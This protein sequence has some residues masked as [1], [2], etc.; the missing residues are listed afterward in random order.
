MEF[1][2]FLSFYST[3][4]MR[5]IQESAQQ[6][7]LLCRFTHICLFHLFFTAVLHQQPPQGQ[8]VEE[9]GQQDASGRAAHRGQR[10]TRCNG[11]GHQGGQHHGGVLQIHGALG[12]V[13]LQIV[14][15][16]V[17]EHDGQGLVAGDHTG[18]QTGTHGSGKG[19]GA[20]GELADGLFDAVQQ[21]G[22]AENTGEGG[23]QADDT[24]HAHHG[25]HAAAVDH[26]G[27]LGVGGLVAA[28]QQGRQLG[29]GGALHQQADGQCILRKPLQFGL[30]HQQA[31]ND[32]HQGRH[33]H[34]AHRHQA[35]G[36]GVGD[37]FL[38][39]GFGVGLHDGDQAVGIGSPQAGNITEHKTKN[40]KHAIDTI[41]I[42][43]IV[44]QW[45]AK[46]GC[47]Y[48][49][50][51]DR[52]CSA[53]YVVGKDGSIGLSVDEKDRSWC[54]SNATNDHRAVTIEVASDKK[55]PYAVTDAA[56]NALISL[57]ADICKRN[58]IKKDCR[59]S[60]SH[61]VSYFSYEK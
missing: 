53:N 33:R 20:D 43:C 51:T 12:V 37:G 26:G 42:H 6:L 36:G 41:T 5:P 32:H 48:F 27:H 18:H 7:L 38:Q 17:G 4:G 59:C 47:D 9:A 40:R 22:A 45:T 19:I 14:T 55:A 46:E 28:E 30:A 34:D 60:R 29:H 57:V 8:Q 61:A 39:I 58:G 11:P 13:G 3:T 49:A 21:A 52:E 10:H 23:G 50:T 54:S 24:G 25:H 1:D 31:A 2:P 56:Y 15:Q 16:L 44:A 35:G